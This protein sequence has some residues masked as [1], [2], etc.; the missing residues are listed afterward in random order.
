MRRRAL[1]ELPFLEGVP[2][3]TR[4]VFVFSVSC[5][6]LACSAIVFGQAQTP[7][8]AAASAAGIPVPRLV[9]SSGV[10]NDGAGKPVTGRVAVMFSLYA[11]QDG[12]TP[13]W[14]ETQVVQADTQGHYTVF[15]GATEPKG[16][17]LDAFTSGAARW[18]GVQPEVTGTVELPRILLV[19]VPYALKAADAD[20]LGG[21]P[22][23]AFV[24]TDLQSPPGAPAGVAPAHSA[25]E[26]NSAAQPAVSPAAVGG[27]GSANFI[28]LWLNST[29]LGN[30][31]FFQMAGNVG[32][33]TMTPDAKLEAISIMSAGIGVHG[34][35]SGTSGAGVKGAA[36]ATSG[37][38][39]GVIGADAS[40]SGVGVFGN[41]TAASGSTIGVQGHATSPA[42]VGVQGGGGSSSA[43]GGT[44]GVG[45]SFRGGAATGAGSFGGKGV[46]ING[47]N[48]V[49]GGGLAISATGGAPAGELDGEHGGDGIDSQGGPSYT[50]DSVGGYG[51]SAFG[52]GGGT[53]G[54]VGVSAQGGSGALGGPGVFATGG[55]GGALNGG[56]GIDAIAGSGS[57]NGLAG[58]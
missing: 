27:S 10:V 3:K 34:A 35:A 8:P 48:G 25:A 16:L 5:L 15:L 31:A 54:G 21:K 38:T 14:S 45:G 28:P 58:S 24:T 46:V 4:S 30:S 43:D 22:A 49:F 11:E 51:V 36:T 7:M 9:S 2:M 41:A 56:A 42:G 33:G 47:G 17:P 29:T 18:L 52:G 26:T 39:Y 32:L 1:L 40:S 53:G 12:G 57:P 23:S 20:T 44:A 13:L 50:F 37:S 6:L 55:N 19:G